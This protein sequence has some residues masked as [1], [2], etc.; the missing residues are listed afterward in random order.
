MAKE[1][2]PKEA[3]LERWAEFDEKLAIYQRYFWKIFP[4][5]AV[6]IILFGI[7]VALIK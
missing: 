1:K 5:A 7:F 6:V 2:D 3:L 4:M